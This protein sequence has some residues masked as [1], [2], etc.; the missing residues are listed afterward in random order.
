MGQYFSNEEIRSNLKLHEFNIFDRKISLY[1]DRGV[2]SKSS[3]DYGTFSLLKNLIDKELKGRVLDL[4]CGYGVIA[5]VLAKLFP[6]LELEAIDVNK[7]A[8]HLTKMNINK[9][10]LDNIL[11]YESDAY[12]KVEGLFDAI[13]TNPPIRAGKAKVYEFLLE[14]KNH[15]KIDGS[16]YLVI[17]KEQ[18]AKSV[19]EELKKHYKLSILDKKKGFFIIECKMFD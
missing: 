1:T 16:L 12:E 5:I 13:V 7:R 14:A 2:F 15:L 6:E 8:I 3:I 10:N 4:G 17:R 11:V 18:G 19:V 9:N